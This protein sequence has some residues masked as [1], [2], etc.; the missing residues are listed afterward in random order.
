MKNL[1]LNL[2]FAATI[3]T[4]TYATKA[5][6]ND[7]EFGMYVAKAVFFKWKPKAI[8]TQSQKQSYQEK[9]KSEKSDTKRA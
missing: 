3:A 1:L 5:Q 9:N 6:T 7:E 2:L 8:K 4:Q